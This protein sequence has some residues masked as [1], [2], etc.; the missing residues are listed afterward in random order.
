MVSIPTKLP[1]THQ[2]W[3]DFLSRRDID[4]LNM[5]INKLER[6][7]DVIVSAKTSGKWTTCKRC[8]STDTSCEQNRTCRRAPPGL[9]DR[10]I[11]CT[12]SSL[13]LFSFLTSFE[14][15]DDLMNW[16]KKAIFLALYIT[17]GT[18]SKPSFL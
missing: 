5:P 11:K 15:P 14:L 10:A 17:P 7:W 9:R 3:C 16:L 1:N 6:E 8:W 18:S 13:T 4:H 2:E 12:Y